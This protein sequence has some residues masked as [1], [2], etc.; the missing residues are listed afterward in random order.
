MNADESLG[1]D[2]LRQVHHALHEVDIITGKLICPETGRE[3][4]IRNGIPNML[5]N[6][7]E[8]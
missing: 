5:C 1:E 2:F 4:L 8:V 3:F 7:T 6:E